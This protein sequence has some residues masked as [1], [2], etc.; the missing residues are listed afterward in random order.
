VNKSKK[1]I[2]YRFFNNDT[3]PSSSNTPQ[4]F[5]LHSHTIRHTWGFKTMYNNYYCNVKKGTCYLGR[6]HV[7]FIWTWKKF[8][9]PGFFLK[10]WLLIQIEH[11]FTTPAS[12][13][14]FLKGPE[15][16]LSSF[17]C[18]ATNM[19]V[20]YYADYQSALKNLLLLFFWLKCSCPKCGMVT[21][22][23]VV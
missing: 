20:L 3:I 14:W 22:F 10:N 23:Q 2:C 16:G 7:Y 6:I 4:S 11:H 17:S 12:P 19:L 15:F 18:H 21:I 9:F 1:D 5:H 13:S 8:L